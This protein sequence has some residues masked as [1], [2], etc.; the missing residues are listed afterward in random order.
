MTAIATTMKTAVGFLE[1][2]RPGGPWVLTAIEPDAD[3][4]VSQ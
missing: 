4:E 2:L 3:R 1:K